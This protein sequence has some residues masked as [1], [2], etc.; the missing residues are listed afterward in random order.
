MDSYTQPSA[1]SILQ[2]N[3]VSIAEIGETTARERKWVLGGLIPEGKPILL[4]GPPGAGKGKHVS[5][6]IKKIII[7]HREY[8]VFMKTF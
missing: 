6:F 5:I 3:L 7:L 1:S 4:G 2:A 8:A